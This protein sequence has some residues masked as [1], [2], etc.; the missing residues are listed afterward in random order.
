MVAHGFPLEIEVTSLMNKRGWHVINQA[1]YKDEDTGK[2]RTIDLW[3]ILSIHPTIGRHDLVHI[4][5]LIECKKSVKPWVFYTG[6]KELCDRLSVSHWSTTQ[7]L[8]WLTH[9]HHNIKDHNE[10]AIIPFEP[11]QGED[12]SDVL[13]ASMQVLK[14]LSFKKKELVKLD[15]MLKVKNNPLYI[16]YPVIV[17]DGNLWKCE[18]QEGNPEISMVQYIEYAVDY[19][20]P[21]VVDIVQKSYLPTFLETLEREFRLI[22]ETVEKL[23]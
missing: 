4:S 15:R 11:F 7:R 2:M 5:L 19:Y 1:Y 17:F 20:Q 6:K 14:A 16:L 13:E 8:E 10:V 23:T 12:K 3:A 18:L 22:S 9:T 21:I